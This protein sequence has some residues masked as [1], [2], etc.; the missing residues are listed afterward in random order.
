[1]HY[2]ALSPD[3]P[4]SRAM[5]AFTEAGGDGDDATLYP[6]E[7]NPRAHTAVVLFSDTPGLVDA[8]LDALVAPAASPREEPLAPR[9]PRRYYWVGQDAVEKLVYPLFQALVLRTLGP[10]RL[11]ASWASF[12]RR[13]VNCKDGTFEAWDPWPWW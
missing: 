6:I 4:Q 9:E 10:G 8:Y 2:T 7:C 1:M 3:A 11:A 5:L 12:G 13:V